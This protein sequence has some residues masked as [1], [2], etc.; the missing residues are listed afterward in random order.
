MRIWRCGYSGGTGH[1]SGPRRVAGAPGITTAPNPHPI[2]TTTYVYTY[3][4]SSIIGKYNLALCTTTKWT[5]NG[6]QKEPQ[7]N[8]LWSHLWWWGGGLAGF[9]GALAGFGPQTGPQT[10]QPR[11]GWAVCGALCGAVCARGGCQAQPLLS[12][13]LDFPTHVYQV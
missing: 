5:T 13:K 7:M 11:R 1:P 4:Y 6:P 3:A 2:P 12:A 10:G 9:G 8:P